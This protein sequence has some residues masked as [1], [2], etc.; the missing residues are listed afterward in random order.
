MNAEFGRSEQQAYFIFILFLS[1]LFIT[2]CAGPNPNPGERTLDHRMLNINNQTSNEYYE[3]Y[4]GEIRVRAEAGIPWAQLRLGNAYK[5]GHNHNHH[6]GI[7]R[8]LVEA[9][10]WYKKAAVQKAEGG[11]AD[12]NLAALFG[13]AGWFGQ[14]DNA[15]IAQV[16]LAEIYL[17]G[18]E[19]VPK[20]LMEAYFNIRTVKEEIKERSQYKGR[21]L[22]FC[23]NFAGGRWVEAEEIERIYNQ[24]IEE[25]SPEQ[26]D[27]AKRLYAQRKPSATLVD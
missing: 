15:R 19:G 10:K 12:G 18:G 16:W 22:F 13:R 4:L 5:L 20:D 14:N 27:E 26:L 7:D 9:V 24:I 8:D 2:G 23:C 17:K 11:W 3:K 21:S 6:G 25:M 1:I